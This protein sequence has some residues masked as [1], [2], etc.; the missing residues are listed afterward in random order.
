MDLGLEGLE[1]EKVVVFML[2]LHQLILKMKQLN[3]AQHMMEVVFIFLLL[4][5][6]LG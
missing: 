4:L 2:I 6:Y 1:M 3:L 5:F